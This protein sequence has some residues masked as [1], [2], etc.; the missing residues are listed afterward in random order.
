M[1][2][3]SSDYVSRPKD[4]TSKLHFD[5][6]ETEKGCQVL[7]INDSLYEE[8]ESFSIALSLPVGGQLGAKFPTARVTILADREDAGID[9]IGVSQNLHFSPGVSV[10]T[11]SDNP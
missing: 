1:E 11:P 7:I 9:Y 3:S 10:Q 2:L 6:G 5:K 8:E 4:N